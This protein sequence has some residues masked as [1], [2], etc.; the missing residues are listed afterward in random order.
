[1][2]RQPLL[3]HLQTLVLFTKSDFKTIIFPVL[4][5]SL[6]VYGD[7]KHLALAPT[8][9]IVTT[10]VAFLWLWA[11]VLVFNIENQT[12]EH[13]LK[14]DNI[15]KPWRP[16]VASR[17]S[18]GGAIHLG[19]L[20]HL[21]NVFISILLKT[22]IPSIIFHEAGSLYNRTNLHKSAMGRNILCAVGYA[23]AGSGCMM[24]IHNVYR[25]VLL[26]EHGTDTSMLAWKWLA[27]FSA[28]ILTTIQITDILDV[29]GDR[30]NGRRTLPTALGVVETGV[31][32]A[33]IVLGWS[34]YLVSVLHGTWLSWLLAYLGFILASLLIYGVCWSLFT[35][36]IACKCYSGWIALIAFVPTYLRLTY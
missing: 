28:V 18:M 23:S 12:Q 14:E 19:Q 32:S 16:I 31:L 27:I 36:E 6:N 34:T 2:S 20:V 13:S 35:V 1:M 3:S 21:F 4:L 17:I 30:Q 24:V 29:D 5:F 26:V 22:T 15:N 25:E 11:H 9:I 33:A 10:L 8:Y 7:L